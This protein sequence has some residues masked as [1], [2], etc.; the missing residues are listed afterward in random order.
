M[1]GNLYVHSSNLQGWGSITVFSPKLNSKFMSKQVLSCQEHKKKNFKWE[2]HITGGN[3][4]Q[5][6]GNSCEDKLHS[7]ILY[8]H[9]SNINTTHHKTL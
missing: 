6:Q 4:M 1:G 2:A 8:I 7:Y 9:N 3:F 5:K